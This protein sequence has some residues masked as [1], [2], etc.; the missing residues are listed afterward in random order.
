MDEDGNPRTLPEEVL[1]GD[2]DS[3]GANP[4]PPPA[5]PE[6]PE[7]PETPEEEEEP[8]EPEEPEQP[9]EKPVSKRENKRIQELT[10]K[11]AESYGKPEGKRP[12][13]TPAERQRIIEEGD[14]TL[15]DINAKAD[16][17]AQRRY[18]EGLAQANSLAFQTRL[19]IDAPRV[20]AKY[21]FLDQDSENFEPGSASFINELYLKTVG[22]DPDSGT[23][24]NPNIR[25][26]EF[27]DGVMELADTIAAAKTVDTKQNIARQA[28]QAG[29]RP[30]GVA[31]PSYQ[32]DD[33]R[34]MSDEQLDQAIAQGLGILKR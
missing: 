19:E 23:V 24:Q 31:K 16:E 30:S 22:Y 27:I 32:G 25:Y 18:N 11:L 28:A 4:T 26:V 3:T 8:E 1:N 2:D 29:V 34:Q 15:E 5:E 9:E 7:E 20:A 13:T 17:Y 6:E 12:P 33:P 14:Y 10:K 21:E